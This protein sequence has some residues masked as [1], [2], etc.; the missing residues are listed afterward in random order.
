MKVEIAT[1]SDESQ[2]YKL[3][4]SCGHTKNG[5]SSTVTYTACGICDKSADYAQQL[6]DEMLA[7]AWK[8]YRPHGYDASAPDCVK[9][10]DLGARGFSMLVS[11]HAA[12]LYRSLEAD[13]TM[14]RKRNVEL[15]NELEQVCKELAAVRAESEETQEELRRLKR[16]YHR[17]IHLR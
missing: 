5:A 11:D 9:Q 13:L 8:A 17:K 10:R 16:A 2:C 3:L 15:A 1:W 4:L 6:A 14:M 7:Q 12:N